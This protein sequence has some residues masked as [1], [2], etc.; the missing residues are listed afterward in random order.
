MV[1]TEVEE[2]IKGVERTDLN[3][4]EVKAEMELVI[5]QATNLGSSQHLKWPT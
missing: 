4:Q 3:L 5:S 2:A 1:E